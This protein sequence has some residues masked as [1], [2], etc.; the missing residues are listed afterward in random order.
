MLIGS[1]IL[2]GLCHTILFAMLFIPILDRTGIK[3]QSFILFF[4]TITLLFGITITPLIYGTIVEDINYVNY[5]SHYQSGRFGLANIV[6]TIYKGL[7][8]IPVFFTLETTH[9]Y[10]KDTLYYKL[11]ILSIVYIIL[12]FSGLETD[13]RFGSVLLLFFIILLLRNMDILKS[14]DK[15]IIILIPLLLMTV[16]NT[17]NLY[18]RMVHEP[19]LPG[20]LL[21][22]QT[23][24]DAPSLP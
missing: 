11:M 18:M 20:N 2:A 17:Y 8:L 3:S 9:Q 13:G 16:F 7:L 15:R 12:Y 23:I 5:L 19:L 24:F 21:V 14:T 1:I 10:S 4:L 6:G 22:Y